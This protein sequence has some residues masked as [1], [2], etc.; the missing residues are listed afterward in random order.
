MRG[1]D[2]FSYSY[3]LIFLISRILFLIPHRVIAISWYGLDLFPGVMGVG[4][5]YVWALRL[6]KRIGRNVYFSRSVEILGWQSLVIGDNVSIHKDCY[7]DA[8]GGLVVGNDVSIAHASSVLT[9]EH[10]WSDA[11]LPIKYN[12]SLFCPVMIEDDV[13]IGCGCRI[14]AG[15]TIGR[16]SIVAAGAVVT[17]DVISGIL[18]GGVPAKIIKRII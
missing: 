12:P 2:F 13:W 14:L 1:R 18:V 3:P 17:R 5:R 8:T 16:R 10:T 9:F 6:A 7:I 4:L 15:V 11:G